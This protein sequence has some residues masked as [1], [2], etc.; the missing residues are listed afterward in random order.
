MAS[1][2]QTLDEVMLVVVVVDERDVLDEEGV[3]CRS[4]AGSG[5]CD[6]VHMKY[7]DLGRLLDAGAVYDG[8]LCCL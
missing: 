3:N 6:E 2:E 7:D 5:C 1:L 8:V 4:S